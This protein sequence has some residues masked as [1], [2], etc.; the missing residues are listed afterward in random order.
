MEEDKEDGK[1][2]T[3]RGGSGRYEVGGG[4]SS[5]ASEGSKC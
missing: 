2:G 3:G 5:V 4:K 1:S